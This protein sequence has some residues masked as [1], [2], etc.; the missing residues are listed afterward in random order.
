MVSD[1]EQ[2]RDQRMSENRGHS[3]AGSPRDRLPASY[4]LRFKGHRAERKVDFKV[5]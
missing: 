1:I 2:G 3:T 5:A 4:L